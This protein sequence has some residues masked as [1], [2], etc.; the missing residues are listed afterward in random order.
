MVGV[1][2]SP[3][4]VSNIGL[5]SHQPEAAES[6]VH[7]D[8]RDQSIPSD[9]T[10]A[11]DTRVMSIDLLARAEKRRV[12]C[13]DGL[14]SRDQ[15]RLG[16]YFTPSIAASMIAAIPRIPTAGRFRILDPGAG[17]GQLSAAVLARIMSQNPNLEVELVGVETDQNVAAFLSHTYEDC[18]ELARE[19][20]VKLDTHVVV[21]DFVELETSIFE[22]PPCLAEP[23]DLVV[24]NPPYFKLAP[25]SPERRALAA[26]G[27]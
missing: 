19:T 25:N 2:G 18:A 8:A 24:M 22:K 21:G 13:L 23:F 9:V 12:D 17:T 14:N 20:G 11:A 15:A 5:L 26:V 6:G 10:P 3:V 7:A 1:M 16:Q 4:A 27:A